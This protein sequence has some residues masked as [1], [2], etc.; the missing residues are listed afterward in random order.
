ME[1]ADGGEPEAAELKK[2]HLREKIA[3]LKEQMQRLK[4]LEVQMLASPDKQLSLTDPDARPLKSR[5]GGIVGYN[6][7]TAADAKHHL[8][9]AHESSPRAADATSS[10]RSPTQRA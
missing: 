7:Q 5:D 3:A 1:T 9:V 2:G 4:A 8:I 6:V 10:S